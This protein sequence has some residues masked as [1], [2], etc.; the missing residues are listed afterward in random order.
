MNFSSYNVDTGEI[1][2]VGW[3][4]PVRM[5][6]LDWIEGHY[7]GRLFYIDLNGEPQPRPLRPGPEFTWNRETGEWTDTRTTEQLQQELYAKR[8]RAQLDK[9]ELLTRLMVMK[10]FTPEQMIEARRDVPAFMMPMLDA[11]SPEARAVAIVKWSSDNVIS[12]NNPV[13]VLAAYALGL[14]DE[15]VDALFDVA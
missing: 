1:T 9:S 13:I 5:G 10:I 6:K 4:Q 14:T 3:G 15:Q 12:R 8:N 11:L 7:D 2:Q